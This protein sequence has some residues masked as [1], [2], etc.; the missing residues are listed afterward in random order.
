MTIAMRPGHRL[1]HLFLLASAIAGTSSG[2]AV[3]YL[4]SHVVIIAACIFQIAAQASGAL[5][6]VLRPR[7]ALNVDVVRLLVV[8]P[9]TPPPV[10][11]WSGWQTSVLSTVHH[12]LTPF[13][14]CSVHRFGWVA[15]DCAV[16]RGS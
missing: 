16:I 13:P 4:P 15:L 1:S 12:S 6:P 5:Q 7:P 14:M 9:G 11:L 2:L 8:V 3:H 10:S